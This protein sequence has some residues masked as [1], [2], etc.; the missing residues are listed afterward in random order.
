VGDAA[1]AKKELPPK[2]AKE[3]LAWQITKELHS[4]E[5]ADAAAE[6]FKKQFAEGGLPEDIQDIT[7]EANGAK[8]IN[9]VE[10]LM[11]GLGKS[12]SESRRLVEQ[13]GVSVEGSKANIESTFPTTGEYVVKYGKRSYARVHWR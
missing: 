10:L 13:G 3:R 8:D 6:A 4:P 7:L 12:R 9:I 11:K 5:K 2:T 1:L